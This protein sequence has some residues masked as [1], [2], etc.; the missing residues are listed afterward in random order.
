V[1]N[2]ALAIAA[3]KVAL[4]TQRRIPVSNHSRKPIRE[5]ALAAVVLAFLAPVGCAKR[6]K[7]SS[8][9][10]ASAADTQNVERME[11]MRARA[12]NAPG[13]TVEASDYAFEVTLL[14][15][16][17]ATQRR[18]V[19]A[20]FADEAL[21]NLDLAVANNPADAGDLL[22][23]KGELL[24][25]LGKN[26]DGLRVLQESI[27]AQP[28]LR[29]FGALGKSYKAQN[30][31]KEVESLCKKTLPAMKSDESRYAV[32]DE[33]IKDGGASSVEAGLRWA[34][35]KDVA[36]YKARRRE[37]EARAA[38]AAKQRAK[39]AQQK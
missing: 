8:T 16:Q 3:G 2:E 11:K 22:A 38:H 33:C 35:A 26:E 24:L 14:Y 31:T 12:L 13:S 15:H 34:P 37:L 6:Q 21:H 10:L 1:C 4:L 32:L 30:K 18:D 39:D 20:T 25:A 27:D 28:N 29:A 17:G 9:E 23:L 7:Q 5:I 36:F 19:P